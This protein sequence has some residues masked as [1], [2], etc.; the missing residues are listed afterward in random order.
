MSFQR[1][2]ND[3]ADEAE[4]VVVVA[5]AVGIVDDAGAGEWRR[6][7]TVLVADWDPFQGGAVAE[8][9]FEGGGGNA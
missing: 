5:G 2:G 9:V 1:D 7:G 6:H 4:D 3:L 8:A